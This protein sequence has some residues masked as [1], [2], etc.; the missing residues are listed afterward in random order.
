LF[1]LFTS[2]FFLPDFPL[3]SCSALQKDKQ[4]LLT[5]IEDMK[6]LVWSSHNRAEEV[7]AR[8]EEELAHAEL[9][10]LGADRDLVQGMKTI[11]DLSKKLTSSDQPFATL[12]KSF[13]TVAKLL[14]TSEDD[15]KTWGEFI[16]L[17]PE[18]LQNF[19]KDGVRA[20]VKNILAH[21]RVLAPSVPLEKLMED[22][23]DDNYLESIE[24]AESEVEDLAN[25]IADKLDIH[26]P[27]FNDEADS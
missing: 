19:V 10:R 25:F 14:R 11:D 15:G 22:T 5:D 2:Y 8:A 7:K 20:C 9:I 1:L 12:W 23:D 6:I 3:L 21:V 18:R 27:P 24:N 17:I 13:K 26:P 4:V 16:P